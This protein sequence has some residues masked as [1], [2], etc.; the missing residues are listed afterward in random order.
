MPT[1]AECIDAAAEVLLNVA[2]RV[3]EDR[4]RALARASDVPASGMSPASD[5]GALLR[6][7]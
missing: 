7:A 5:A 4:L 1:Y 2:I 3:E 6:T